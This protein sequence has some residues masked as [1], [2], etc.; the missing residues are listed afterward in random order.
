MSVYNE[1][2]EWIKQAIDSILAQSYKDFEFIIVNDKPDRLENKQV[3]DGYS[4]QDP[5]IIVISNEQNI[6]LTKSLNKA[7]EIA[8]GDYIARMDADDIAFS[9]R[10]E[11]QVIFL[12]NHKNIDICGSSIL[13]FGKIDME[14][15]FP[16]DN[17]CVYLFVE[18]C[19]AHPTVMGKSECF[20]IFRYH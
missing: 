19:F 17:S 12:N 5:R 15:K 3:L 1:P 11:T 8:C 10:L 9:E 16:L 4:K 13:C 20:K 2:V 6:G 14:R 18:N 7:I